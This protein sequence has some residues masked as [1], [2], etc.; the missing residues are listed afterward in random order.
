MKITFFK[1]TDLEKPIRLAVHRS[2]RLGFPKEAEPKLGL[3]TNKSV[4]IGRNAEDETDENL[5]MIANTDVPEGSF[6]IGKAGDYYYVN[7][8]FLLDELKWEYS[9]GQI[10][11]DMKRMDVD[12]QTFFK[13][14]KVNKQ[15]TEKTKTTNMTETQT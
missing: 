3:G 9:E 7:T 15:K 12:G 1:S 4:S 2:G 13:L 6:E 10:A 14:T 5:Y 11:F 8:R